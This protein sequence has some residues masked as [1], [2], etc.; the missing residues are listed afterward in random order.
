MVW[1]VDVNTYS[2]TKSHTFYELLHQA[3]PQD[4]LKYDIPAWRS[5]SGH[6][7]WAH[8]GHQELAVAAAADTLP[9][10]ARYYCSFP[11]K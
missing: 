4:F 11:M 9:D 5:S 6:R 10:D 1:I 8:C 2:S 7:S 3:R